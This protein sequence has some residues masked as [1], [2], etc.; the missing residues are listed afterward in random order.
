MEESLMVAFRSKKENTERRTYDTIS[1]GAN[2]VLEED[3][4]VTQCR[5]Y[6]V[7]KER[8]SP[9]ELC[10]IDLLSLYRLRL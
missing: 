4:G 7:R 1:M 5:Q 3:A 9:E 10:T 6:L 2:Q 8:Q